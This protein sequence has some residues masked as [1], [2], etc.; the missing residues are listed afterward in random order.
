MHFK[1]FVILPSM[2]NKGNDIGAQN[3]KK[4]LLIVRHLQ[5]QNH[6]RVP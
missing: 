3:N 6:I 4:A 5:S 2:E 1:N